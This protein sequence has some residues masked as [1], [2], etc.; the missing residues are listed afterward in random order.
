MVFVFI[1]FKINER[2]EFIPIF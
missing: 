2:L 1:N